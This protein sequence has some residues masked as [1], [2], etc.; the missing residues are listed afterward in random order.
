MLKHFNEGEITLRELANLSYDLN[1]INL[2]SQK[3]YEIIV[4]YFTKHAFS[5]T[6]LIAL[7]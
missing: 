3:I 2:K 7:G 1:I 6:D 5:D 4:D